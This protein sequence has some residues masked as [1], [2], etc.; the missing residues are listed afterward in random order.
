MQ[1]TVNKVPVVF[2]ADTGAAKTVISTRV[3]HKIRA[4]DRP[5][6]REGTRLIGAGGSRIKELGKGSFRLVLGPLEIEEEAIVAEIQDD[7]LLGYDILN[8]KEGPADILLSKNVILLRGHEIPCVKGRQTKKARCVV[9]ADDTVVPGLSEAIVGVY[10]ERG[11][12]DDEDPDS[13]F[14]LEPKDDFSARYKLM[15]APSLVDI[16]REPTCKVR[17]MNPFKD[18]VKLRQAA[19]IAT[20]EKVSKLVSVITDV[21][22]KECADDMNMV[23]RLQINSTKDVSASIKELEELG[24][25]E[26]PEHLRDLHTRSTNGKSSFQKRV[27]AGLLQKYEGTFSKDEWDIGLTTLAEHPIKTGDAAPIKQRPRRVPIAYAD[28]EK[29]AIEDLLQKGVIQKSTSPWASPIVLVKKKSGEMRPCVDYR[30]VNALVKPD[31]FPLPRVQDCLDAVSGSAF[32]SSLDLT[33]GYF[34]IPLK[35]E[36]IPKSAFCCKFGHFEMT[37]MPFG[38]NNSSGTFQRTMEL[39]H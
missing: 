26:L 36:D 19:E 9:V 17:V 32:F 16:N 15:M 35:K 33:S 29:K 5:S 4:Q 8:S 7:V 23:R 10:V 27:V 6:L 3:Y 11:D 37:R 25:G 13:T 12:S 14:V 2:T 18:A 31:G 1:G 20:A 21:E 28:E 22:D 24:K 38:L 39:A 34:Q 30:K